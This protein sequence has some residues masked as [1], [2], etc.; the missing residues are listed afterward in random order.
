M[1]YSVVCLE[2]RW[3]G[4]YMGD[5]TDTKANVS[6]IKRKDI[7]DSSKLNAIAEE[8]PKVA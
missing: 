8:E 4:N 5:T 2:T 1:Q 3:K 6:V 7:K